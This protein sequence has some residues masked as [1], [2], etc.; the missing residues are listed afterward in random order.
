M[1]TLWYVSEFRL[2]LSDSFG[3]KDSISDE[4]S[5]WDEFRSGSD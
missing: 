2:F 1:V 3:P 4:V 5:L